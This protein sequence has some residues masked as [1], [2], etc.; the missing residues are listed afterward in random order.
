MPAMT[1]ASAGRGLD[2]LVVAVA[3]LDRAAARWSA[4]GF[5]V[6]AENRHPFGT[7]NRL[8]QL[9]G[10][11][12]ELLAM[13]DVAAIPPHAGRTFSFPTFNRDFLARAGEGPSMLALESRD[14]KADALAFA[15]DGIGDFEPFFFERRGMRPDGSEVHVAFTLSF[16]E[17]ADMPDAGFFVCQQHRPDDFWNPAFHTHSN[18]AVGVASVMLTAENPTD[19][20]IFLTAFTG[21][22]DFTSTSTGLVFETP[23]GDVEMMTPVAFARR[24]GVMVDDAPRIRGLR[25][26]VADLEE[27]ALRFGVNG[28][29]A[30]RRGGWLMVGPEDMDGVVVAFEQATP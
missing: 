12:V 21:I 30:V 1:R 13:G 25:F 18:G 26:A 27:T 24:C 6:G 19:H 7:R 28:V 2:H 9:P 17:S 29:S 5:Q 22:R 23:R 15:K 10:F 4:L 16:A 3:D 11:F 14:A 8:I 20:H